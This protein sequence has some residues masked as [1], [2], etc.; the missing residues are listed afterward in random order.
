MKTNLLKGGFTYG[1]VTIIARIASIVLI[2]VLTRLLSPAQYG[3]LNLALTVVSLAN[4]FITLEVAQ[5]VTYF[6]TNRNLAHRDL[7]PSSALWFS[8]AMYLVFFAIAALVGGLIFR[9]ITGND[10]GESIIINSAL[11]LAANGTFLLVQNQ[12]RLEFKSSAYALLTIIYV[13]LTIF[14]AILGALLYRNSAKAVIFGQAAGAT[15]A[16]VIGIIMLWGSFRSGLD[17]TKLKQMLKYSLPLVPAG[18]L[19]IGGQQIPKFI[20]STYGSLADVGIYGLAYQIAGF[21]ALAVLGV[22]TAITPSILSNH[23]KE[24]TPRMLGDLFEG[25][26]VVAFILCSALSIFSNELIMVFS[27]PN[28]AGAAKLVP[29]LAFSIVLNA[30][31]I[32]FPGKFIKGRSKA[33]LIPSIACFTVAIVAGI[34]LVKID[35][36]RGAAIATLLSSISFFFIWCYISQKLYPL[37]INWKRI[38]VMTV[39]TAS[40][41]AAGSLLLPSGLTFFIIILKCSSLLLFSFLIGRKQIIPLWNR[42]LKPLFEK[43]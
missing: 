4:I 24:E 9:T 1:S 22:Q 30:F 23:E 40:F 33:Q 42:Y 29:I 6:Y 13:A 7:Y 12:L 32:F 16:D 27:S 18:L 43:N 15:V 14:G 5:A 37:P 41:C 36:V 2:A 11:L 38:L 26:V 21:S 31:Y 19:L 17:T 3:T 34:A 8:L 20:L 10:I 35:A 25:F 39:F 28:Y